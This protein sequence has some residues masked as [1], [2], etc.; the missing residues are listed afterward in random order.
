MG[1]SVTIASTIVLIGLIAFAGSLS[2]TMFCAINNVFVLLNTVSDKSNVQLEL[3]IVSVNA[4]EIQFY[5]RNTGSKVIF[6]LDQGFKWNSAVVSYN[7]SF[8]RSYLIEDYTILEIKVT[9]T[10][11]S[12]NVNTHSCVNP[13]EEVHIQASLPSGAP[14]IPIN[15]TFI[16]VFASHYGV[17][18]IKE[19]VRT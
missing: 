6:L 16:V 14:E 15:G 4:S 10:N 7:N 19:G 9:G 1:F 17:G 5:V 8:W 3:E 18:A 11:V 13:G 12:F 2:T